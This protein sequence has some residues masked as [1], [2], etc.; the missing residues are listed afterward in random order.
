MNVRKSAVVIGS[1][2]ILMIPL[3]RAYGQPKP[4]VVKFEPFTW[5]SEPPADCPS[6][7]PG[8]DGDPF[9]GLQE[10]LPLWGHLVPLL[11]RGRQAVFA[12]DGRLVL[13]PGRLQRSLQFRGKQRQCRPH[14]PGRHRGERSPGPQGLQPGPAR[15]PGGPLSRPLSLRQPG[16]QGD[17]VLRHILPGPGWLGALRADHRE[18]ALAGAL[19]RVPRLDGPRPVLE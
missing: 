7:G 14:R 4:E 10:R 5:R 6:N 2:L 9:P 19:R 17:L 15:L 1:L 13:A 18:L 8:T 16:L 11:G 3:Q 12:L